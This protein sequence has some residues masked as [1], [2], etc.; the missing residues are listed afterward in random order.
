MVQAIRRGYAKNITLQEWRALG[1]VFALTVAHSKLEDETYVRLIAQA[2]RSDGQPPTKSQT[3]KVGA[4]LGRLAALGIINYR[5][6]TGCYDP[7]RKRIEFCLIGLPPASADVPIPTL[8]DAIGVP[9]EWDLLLP[10]P[11]GA[12][13][14]T[15]KKPVG[16]AYS[17][18]TPNRLLRDGGALE[19][20]G[21]NTFGDVSPKLGSFDDDTD[22]Y[23]ARPGSAVGVDGEGT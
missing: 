22:P 16:E 20:F 17:V 15:E 18:G 1:A 19:R 10:P 21:H 14:V 11:G 3:G 8:W 13:D 12:R 9:T 23:I 2:I 6:S 7:A 5:A 4:A